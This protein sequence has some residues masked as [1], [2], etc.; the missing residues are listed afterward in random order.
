MNISIIVATQA[1]LLLTRPL[2]QGLAHIT[3]R[4]L[5]THHEPDLAGRVRRDSGVGVFGDGED[6]LACLFEVG[7][8]LE[9][10]PLVFS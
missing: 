3:L 7:D 8:E 2:P 5:A 6:F 1:L 4:I 10:E 9:V